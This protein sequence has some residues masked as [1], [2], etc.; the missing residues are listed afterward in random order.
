MTDKLETKGRLTKIDK[1]IADNIPKSIRV[2]T[3]IELVKGSGNITVPYFPLGCSEK[4]GAARHVDTLCPSC[5]ETWETSGYR[6]G[7]VTDFVY[8]IKLIDKLKDRNW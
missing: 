2:D 4:L 3:V 8:S 6:A 7:R 1:T 5:L